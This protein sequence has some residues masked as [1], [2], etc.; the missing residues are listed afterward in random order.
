MRKLDFKPLVSYVT[1]DDLKLFLDSGLA[2]RRSEMNPFVIIGIMVTCFGL[3]GALGF[4]ITTQLLSLPIAVIL[5][6]LFVAVGIWVGWFYAFTVRN[7]EYEPMLRM[8]RFAEAN[9]FQ[10]DAELQ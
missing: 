2:T 5:F 7:R 10:Y 1:R 9:G 8:K 6:V 4:I 3:M